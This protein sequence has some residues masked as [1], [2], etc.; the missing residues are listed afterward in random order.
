MLNNCNHISS[1]KQLNC[2]PDHFWCLKTWVKACASLFPLCF[3]L[4]D[5]MQ[6]TCPLLRGS[7]LAVVCA[8]H[9]WSVSIPLC[10][11]VRR[12]ADEVLGVCDALLLMVLEQDCP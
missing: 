11:T 12:D 10:V 2:I 8:Q 7:D 3:L 9:F 6:Y 5:I 4:S 1:T